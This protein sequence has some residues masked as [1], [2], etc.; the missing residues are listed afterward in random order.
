M[1]DLS[2]N[3]DMKHL[4]TQVQVAIEFGYDADIVRAARQQQHFKC[5]ADLLD[6]IDTHPDL[7][8]IP[9][10]PSPSP[11]SS[12]E[13]IGATPVLTSTRPM[14]NL[15]RETQRLYISSKCYVCGVNPREHLLLPCSE[16]LLCR[17]CLSN[18]TEC[19]RCFTPIREVIH[20]F[21]N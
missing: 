4:P 1:L 21:I 8:P 3:M 19:P 9:P 17:R 13:D 11:P 7:T 18:R 16:F 15:L 10:S 2:R 20:V 14:A 12:P 5:A 6:Y